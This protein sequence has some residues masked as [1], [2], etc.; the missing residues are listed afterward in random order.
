MIYRQAECIRDSM[1]PALAQHGVHL[2]HWDDLTAAHM[3]E[4]SDYFDAQIS[5]AP[6]PLVIDPAH[7]FPFLSILSTSRWRI[8]YWLS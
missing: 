6:T 7:P 3:C 8:L 5:P 1:M 2:R 4:A